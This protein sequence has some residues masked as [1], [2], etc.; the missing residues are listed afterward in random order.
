MTLGLFNV[1]GTVSTTCGNMHTKFQSN[2][3]SDFRDND[4][5]QYWIL[6]G[7]TSNNIPQNVWKCGCLTWKDSLRCILKITLEKHLSSEY[8]LFISNIYDNFSI[9]VTTKELD[10]KAK[11]QKSYCKYSF[12]YSCIIKHQMLNYPNQYIPKDTEISPTF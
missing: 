5:W 3:K 4:F 1:A 2:T 10:I 6:H 11:N 8:E 9:K 7:P 12:H